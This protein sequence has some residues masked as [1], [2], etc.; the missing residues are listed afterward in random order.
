MLGS[1]STNNKPIIIQKHLYIKEKEI[2]EVVTKSWEVS[3]AM[4]NRRE[5]QFR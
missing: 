3:R 2:A 4:G 5:R 1:E